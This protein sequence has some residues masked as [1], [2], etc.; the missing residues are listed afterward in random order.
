MNKVRRKDITGKKVF[1]V[2]EKYYFE[3]IALRNVVGGFGPGDINKVLE[4]VVYS[5]LVL[6]GYNVHVGRQGGREVDFVAEQSGE[7]IYVQVC[8]LLSGDNVIER[9]F[10]N[11][12]AIS[13]NFRKYVV[14]MDEFNTDNT[15]QGI[16]NRHIA[17][18]CLEL[19][20]GK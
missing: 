15:Y 20:N 7:T 9:E 11:L 5:H 2:G 3:D 12:M 17:D 13:D 1:E 8:Y 10:G 6:A 4:N 14:S 19:I 18:F 16:E